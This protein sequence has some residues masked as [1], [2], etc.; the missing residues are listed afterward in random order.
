MSLKE[1]VLKNRSY[2]RFDQTKKIEMKLLRE[3]VDLARQ[4]PSGTNRQPL[5]Y[6]L[7]SGEAK[8][9]ELFDTLKWAGYLPE[10]DGPAEGER[11]TAYVVLIHDKSI[12]PALIGD[13][14][15]PVQTILLAATEAGYGGCILGAID[16]PKIAE[17]IQLPEQ[18][19]VLW[20]IAL[21]VP[22][23]EIHMTE[24]GFDGDIKYYRDEKTVHYVPKR[25][26]AEITISEFE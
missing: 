5:K 12:M 9:A 24:V 14:G 19:E 18:M 6:A 16:R 15:I 23:E 3:W 21:G 17:L 2:R 8:A 4:T 7:I 11:P 13:Q 25:S 10:W 26:L 22:A 20:V 1:L